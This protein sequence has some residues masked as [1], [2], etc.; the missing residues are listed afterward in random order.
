MSYFRPQKAGK[1]GPR[2]IHTFPDSTSGLSQKAGQVKRFK[3]CTIKLSHSRGSLQC[4]NKGRFEKGDFGKS[5]AIRMNLV[6]VRR[7]ARQK[8][9]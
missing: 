4:T 5:F 9:G 6:D 2:T 1:I 7:S 8:T 3:V